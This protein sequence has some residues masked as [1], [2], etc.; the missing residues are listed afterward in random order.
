MSNLRRTT[1]ML[2]A[3]LKLKAVRTASQ[4]GISL[5]ELIRQ[6]LSNSC[7]TK[8]DKKNVFVADK[9]TFDGDVPE[10]ASTNLDHYLYG[11]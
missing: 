4:R 9:I 10:D 1:V 6:T 7:A 2:P 11:E 8:T 5:G 3:D